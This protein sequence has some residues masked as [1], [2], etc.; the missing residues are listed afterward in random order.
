MAS[1]LSADR[2]QNVHE[3]GPSGFVLSLL[4]ICS[5]AR[6]HIMQCPLINS[7]QR[8]DKNDFEEGENVQMLVAHNVLIFPNAITKGLSLVYLC[9][10]NSDDGVKFSL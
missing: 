3:H 10:H 4:C 1:S 9:Y 2:G 6:C 8:M 7:R 5:E